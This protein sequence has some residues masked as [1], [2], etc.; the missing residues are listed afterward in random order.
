MCLAMQKSVILSGHFFNRY[1]IS[2]ATACSLCICRSCP[3][4]FSVV[5]DSI[6]KNMMRYRLII[7]VIHSSFVAA[8]VCYRFSN[9]DMLI[10]YT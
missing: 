5:P 8:L 3:C 2:Y 1:K 4:R 6:F 7:L 10:L 9:F